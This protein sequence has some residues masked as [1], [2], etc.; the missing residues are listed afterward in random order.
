MRMFCVYI[1]YKPFQ[2]LMRIKS[3]K[4]I[5]NIPT[6]NVRTKI[7]RTIRKPLFQ[8][9]KEMHWLKWVLEVDGTDLYSMD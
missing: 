7:L 6:V 8:N 9:D 3:D 5:I 2:L 4:N 1:L